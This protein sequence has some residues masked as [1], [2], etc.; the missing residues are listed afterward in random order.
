M[1]REGGANACCGDD[2]DSAN[3]P[4]GSPPCLMETRAVQQSRGVS[5]VAQACLDIGGTPD[6][7]GLTCCSSSCGLCGGSGCESRPGGAGACCGDVLKASGPQCGQPPCTMRVDAKAAVARSF[8]C[9]GAGGV[10]DESGLFCCSNTCGT[11]GGPGCDNREGGASACC[12]DSLQAAN[13]PCGD[14]P[15]IMET[16]VTAQARDSTVFSAKCKANG[17]ISDPSGLKCCATSCGVCGG[18]GCET[19]PGGAEQCCGDSLAAANKTCGKP[20]CIFRTNPREAEARASAC[21]AVGGIL[22]P[23]GLAC[24][25]SSCGACGGEGCSNHPGGADA[26][27][28]DNVQAANKLC[29]HPPC[30][31][32]AFSD[33]TQN[34]SGEWWQFNSGDI[35]GAARSYSRFESGNIVGAGRSTADNHPCFGGLPSALG[36]ERAI[37]SDWGFGSGS[38]ASSMNVITM[39]MHD[40]DVSAANGQVS[41]RPSRYLCAANVPTLQTYTLICR[42]YFAHKFACL[43]RWSLSGLRKIT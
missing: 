6:L 7:L 20:G 21:E 41:T 22:D 23:D 26:C 13:V 31:M 28:G 35:V 8:A 27:C 19:R 18:V 9:L 34:F 10:P 42:A 5:N 32:V 40:R 15:C 39:K 3:V 12:V 1:S 38:I 4:C 14:P 24:C 16:H 33:G 2:I 25:P 17:G 36:L 29:G 37:C 43:A 11:C 30:L